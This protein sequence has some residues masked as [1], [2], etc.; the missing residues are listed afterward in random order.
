MFR[1]QPNPEFEAE[2]SYAIKNVGEIKFSMPIDL[3]VKENFWIHSDKTSKIAALK[4]FAANLS[5][6][7]LFKIIDKPDEEL[8][9]AEIATILHEVLGNEKFSE[10]VETCVA[11]SKNFNDRAKFILEN[12]LPDEI[13]LKHLKYLNCENSL[14][15]LEKYFDT[16]TVEKINYLSKNMPPKEIIRVI[17]DQK[18]FTE[19]ISS[20]INDLNRE[21]DWANYLIDD[22]EL[23]KA[24]NLRDDVIIFFVYAFV[25]CKKDL[26]VLADAL[27][28]KKEIIKS[29]LRLQVVCRYVWAAYKKSA[30][31]ISAA[32]KAKSKAEDALMGIFNEITERLESVPKNGSEF[33]FTEYKAH[34]LPPC[35]VKLKIGIFARL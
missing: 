19:K 30:G 17:K 23:F 4:N 16:L 29:S 1:E 12:E 8:S 21:N 2:L 13:I 34:I 24:T 10:L 22:I 6:E 3:A 15:V 33:E 7:E 35:T 26:N 32:E 14:T 28:A 9:I 31:N 27:L 5:A 11:Q 20:L 18:T 25:K